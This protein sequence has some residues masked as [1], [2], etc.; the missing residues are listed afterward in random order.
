MVQDSKADAEY[1]ECL[2]KARYFDSVREPIGL[3][4]TLRWDK[5]FVR[6]DRHLARM[7]A[8]AAFLSLPFDR[9]AATAALSGAVA[10]AREPMRVRLT[11][12]EQGG[13]ACAAAPLGPAP[14]RWTFALSPHRVAS[15]DVL[16]RHKTTWRAFYDEEP[17]RLAA[18]EALFCNERGELTEGSR[19][20]IF[21]RR[22]GALVTPPLS[23]GL[24]DGVL[25]RELIEQGRCAEAVLTP[26]DLA[27]ADEVLLGQFPA[28]PD[29]RRAGRAGAGHGLSDA[30]LTDAY[31][32]GYVL[33]DSQRV[34]DRECRTSTTCSF[35]RSPTRPGG[36][37]SS[38]CAAKARRPSGP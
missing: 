30:G 35:E 15:T 10:R 7:A 24:L 6:P 21:L 20:T 14:S 38:G 3:I 13:F 28:R 18:D 19:S 1:A 17:A 32:A 31:P 11:L 34:I 25:R 5:G 36:R 22:G 4:E 12:D 16:L 8:S 23:S 2:L 37:S 33:I 29:P 27:N 26:D 9:D